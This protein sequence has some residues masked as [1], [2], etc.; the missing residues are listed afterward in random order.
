MKILSITITISIF[1]LI[2]LTSIPAETQANQTELPTSNYKFLC[3]RYMM[4]DIIVNGAVSPKIDLSDERTATKLVNM[5]IEFAKNQCQASSLVLIRLRPRDPATFTNLEDGFPRYLAQILEYPSDTVKGQYHIKHNELIITNL[6]KELKDKQAAEEAQK[7]K[8]EEQR[9]AKQLKEELVYKNSADFISKNKIESWLDLGPLAANPFVYEGKIIGV[10]VEFTEMLTATR[11]NFNNE[12]IISDIPK[13]MFTQKTA[14]VIAGKVLG[15]EHIKNRFGGKT[16]LPHLQFKDVY[17]CKNWH[18]GDFLIEPIKNY[19]ILK[20]SEIKAVPEA[21]DTEILEK[22]EANE[23]YPHKKGF[24]RKFQWDIILSSGKKITRV[25]TRTS[26]DGLLVGNRY[27]TT[28]ISDKGKKYYFEKNDKGYAWVGYKVPGETDIRSFKSPQLF[29]QLPVENQSPWKKTE[30]TYIKDNNNMPIEVTCKIKKITAS[31]AV[32][33]GTFNDYVEVTCVYSNPADGLVYN[34]KAYFA[35]GVGVVKKEH[36]QQG[37]K[38]STG[39]DQKSIIQLLSIENTNKISE[40]QT[41]KK[42]TSAL[43]IKLLKRKQVL[44]F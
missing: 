20:E 4:G 3:G 27:W 38:K 14:T 33:A 10:K 9:L 42:E 43:K 1:V 35:K 31:I 28:Q 7:R 32:P 11:A 34:S 40:D 8:L 41:I 29:L 21:K 12:I 2:V 24:I 36:F 22:M 25:Y 26:I 15:K 39:G 13:G 5:A 30:P 18:C 17:F 44:K 37:F 23:Y 16:S 19:E 6:P